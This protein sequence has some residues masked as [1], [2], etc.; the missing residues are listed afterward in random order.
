MIIIQ[1]FF[2][3]L[4]IVCSTVSAII[5]A[6]IAWSPEAERSGHLVNLERG[7]VTSREI[8]EASNGKS[9]KSDRWYIVF[10]VAF[11]LFGV[12]F[13]MCAIGLGL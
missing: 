3:I 4:A 12:V 8:Q 1:L 11:L 2:Q 7:G 9:Y 6:Y 5:F 13:Q 10:G